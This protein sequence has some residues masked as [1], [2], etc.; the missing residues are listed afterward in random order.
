MNTQFHGLQTAIKD[1]LNE[2][3]NFSAYAI[4]E[5]ASAENLVTIV[6]TYLSALATQLD[7]QLPDSVYSKKLI[8]FGI[9]GLGNHI[10]ETIWQKYYLEGLSLQATANLISYSERNTRRLIAKLPALIAE[11]LFE[12]N[13]ELFDREDIKP[14]TVTQLRA[15]RLMDAFDLTSRQAEIL[16]V[17]CDTGKYLGQKAI[18]AKLHLSEAGLKKHIRKIIRKLGVGNRGEAAIKAKHILGESEPE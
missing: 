15:M 8:T 14:N 10:Y 5:T 1:Y 16:L 12:K 7:W 9:T 4:L 17:F 18:C 13:F 11:Q 3:R 6:N 2:K